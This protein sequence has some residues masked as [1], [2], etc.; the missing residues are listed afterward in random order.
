MMKKLLLLSLVIIISCSSYEGKIQGPSFLVK[1]SI[2]IIP[3]GNISKSRIEFVKKNLLET[4]QVE[5]TVGKGLPLDTI[6][7]ARSSTRQGYT[8]IKI[9][10]RFSSIN[11]A[12]KTLLLIEGQVYTRRTLNGVTYPEWSILGLAYRNVCLVVPIRSKSRLQKVAIHEVGHTLGLPH[13]E[14]RGCLMTDAKGNAKNI[15]RA[16]TE[17]CHNCIQK[18]RKNYFLFKNIFDQ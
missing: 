9:L 12:R 10:Q 15:D 16:Q 1:P 4:Y 5:V 14:D 18:M 17:F 11:S 8:G 6:S 3:V 7:F 13:C 2:E